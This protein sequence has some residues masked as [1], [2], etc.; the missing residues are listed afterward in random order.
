MDQ[1]PLRGLSN[2]ELYSED[3]VY[4]LLQSPVCGAS[5]MP[6]CLVNDLTRDETENDVFSVSKV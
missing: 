4:F 6:V 2:P 5:Q 1:E 3:L